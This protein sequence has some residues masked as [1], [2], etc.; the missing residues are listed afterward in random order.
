[1]DFLITKISFWF[2]IDFENKRDS[3]RCQ[4]RGMFTVKEYESNGIWI[5]LL[6]LLSTDARSRK[7]NQVWCNSRISAVDFYKKNKFKSR[8]NI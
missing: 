3:K 6:T 5:S 7:V 4:I 1:M 2:D 8:K